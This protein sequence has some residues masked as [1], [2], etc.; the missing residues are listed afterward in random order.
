M[1][2]PKGSRD[3]ETVKTIEDCVTYHQSKID[4]VTS[5][6]VLF[7]KKCDAAFTDQD[8]NMNTKEA[9]AN[10]M[11]LIKCYFTDEKNDEI[12]KVFRSRLNGGTCV[13][14]HE[15]MATESE[16][17]YCECWLAAPKKEYSYDIKLSED[18]SD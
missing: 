17:T 9:V 12:S 11:S 18:D 1:D 2:R 14:S 15:S 10:S 8:P 5:A 13:S 3:H 4:C 16:S 7:S 6:L